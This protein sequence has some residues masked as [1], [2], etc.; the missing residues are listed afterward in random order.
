MNL[1]GGRPKGS[2]FRLVQTLLLIFFLP[3]NRPL[4]VHSLYTLQPLYRALDRSCIKPTSVIRG[5]QPSASMAKSYYKNPPPPSNNG[6][7]IHFSATTT[8]GLAAGSATL[9][10]LV[11]VFRVPVLLAFFS[12]HLTTFVTPTPRSQPLIHWLYGSSK[13]WRSYGTPYRAFTRILLI[14]RSD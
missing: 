1:T 12:S 4:A 14:D 3:H 6:Y 11:L 7:R 10:V 8:P 13:V 2:R 5:S 9:F